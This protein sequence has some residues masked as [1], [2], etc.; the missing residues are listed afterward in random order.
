MLRDDNS[1]MI[2]RDMMHM[3]TSDLLKLHEEYSMVVTLDRML[4]SDET[5]EILSSIK[6]MVTELTHDL[7]APFVGVNLYLS[8]PD[9]NVLPP[10]TDRYDVFVLQLWG[11]KT[12]N[13]CIPFE[14]QDRSEADR[15]ELHEVRQDKE[16]G[17]TRYDKTELLSDSK[18]DCDEFEMNSGDTLYMPKG[19]IHVAHTEKR[20]AHLT[21]ALPMRGFTLS[22]MFY[23]L[24]HGDTNDAR[25]KKDD[26][27]C[28]SRHA[29]LNVLR[30]DA[31]HVEGL[32]WR[33]PLAEW[34]LLLDEGSD[35]ILEDK[36]EK[37]R[38]FLENNILKNMK[39]HLTREIGMEG[40]TYGCVVP[41]PSSYM[42]RVGMAH[43]IVSRAMDKRDFSVKLR[44]FL[45]DTTRPKSLREAKM[46]GIVTVRS[47]PNRE[48]RMRRILKD[49]RRVDSTEF[50]EVIVNAVLRKS[51]RGRNL[52]ATDCR[53]ACL[54]ACHVLTECTT[55][56]EACDTTYACSCDTVY[57]DSCDNT[58]PD[59]CDTV[60]NNCGGWCGCG[61]CCNTCGDN[62]CDATK[63]DNN[64]D[65]VA[66]DNNCDA[67]C[68]DNNCDD[69]AF[70]C[71]CPDCPSGKYVIFCSLSLLLSL[72]LSL[73]LSLHHSR[74][75][76]T[77][78]YTTDNKVTC[79]NCAQ[80]CAAGQYRSGCGGSEAGSCT[81]CST[82]S[83]GQYITGHGGLTDSCPTAVCP[84]CEIGNYNNGCGGT[85]S[86]SCKACTNAAAG[87][88]YITDG[89]QSNTCGVLNCQ[90]TC[91]IGKYRSGCGGTSEGT[92]VDCT[93]APANSYYTS[94]GGLSDS[95]SSVECQ[96]TCGVGRYR[97][98]CGGTQSGTCTDCTGLPVDHYWTST[99]GLTNTCANSACHVES[100]GV[101]YYLSG[102]S[103]TFIHSHTYIL[104][105]SPDS[106]VYIYIYTY[107]HT[108]IQSGSCEACTGL[109]TEEYWTSNG[110]LTDSCAK[111]TCDKSRCGTGQYL[112]GC[113]GELSGSCQACTN[114]PGPGYYFKTNGD[115]NS[116]NCV[117]HICETCSAGFY[118]SG[119]GGSNE[120]I[121][122]QCTN[123][124]EDQ[125]YTGDGGFTDNCP[126]ATCE[127]NCGSGQYRSGCSG[128]T[129]SGEC[130]ACPTCSTEGQYRASCSGLDSGVCTNCDT[131]S[132]AAGKYRAGCSGTDAGSCVDCTTVSGKYFDGNGGLTD[133]CST[134]ACPSCPAGQYRINCEGEPY[135][136]PGESAPGSCVACDSSACGVGTYLASCSGVNPGSC[137]DC[138]PCSDSGYERMN[139]G[140]LNDGM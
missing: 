31:K 108:G 71:A 118:R 128:T 109:G 9:A 22:D 138:Q 34:K 6:N 120:G 107:T 117:Y 52:Y 62:N 48:N 90:T 101:G 85:D 8:K 15:A 110:G 96:Q 72:S 126:V 65:A 23:F 68:G 102:C 80:N 122:V 30:N 67:T 13:T 112:N 43:D 63:G 113:G 133:S 104:S 32:S 129:S 119:C 18:M 11:K 139:C 140:G 35:S 27:S 45:S 42:D 136:L 39:S 91:G 53:E 5:P 127:T 28:V 21:I 121:C 132:C 17:C 79:T 81:S 99:G 97:T 76:I 103:G 25:A 66:G 137:A 82:P 84:T 3:T 10:H 50:E 55:Y 74:T 125:Y 77:H 56:D 130:E 14:P 70:V 26:V 58:S 38:Q 61:A 131:T 1:N 93:N 95:C 12:W 16:D 94:G 111:S 89:G 114:L 59:S 98:G 87:Q 69:T 49:A 4:Q 20:S 73:F 24:V 135:V 106:Y 47:H 37:V 86:G 64:C 116:N 19:T 88:Y 46:L 44:R 36:I 33:T 51:T 105:L 134:L 75:Q 7:S 100:C 40:D 78:R 57:A 2:R 29:L 83:D 41:P 60:S 123:A 92:C 124:N 54:N 115:V